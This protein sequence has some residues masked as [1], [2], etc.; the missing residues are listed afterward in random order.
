M[1][2]LSF[3]FVS[4]ILSSAVI[5][6]ADDT[7]KILVGPNVLVS[8]D[9]DIPHVELIVASNPKNPKNLVGAA[10]AQSSANGSWAT[11]T[12]S[13]ADSGVSWS[14]NSFP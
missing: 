7:Y 5:F 6:A 9:G 11:K 4:L 2:L 13:S 8:R 10:I 14:H 3:S 12:Y 1:R